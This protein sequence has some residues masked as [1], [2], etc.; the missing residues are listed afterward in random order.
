MLREDAAYA[1]KAARISAL[2]KDVTELMSALGLAPPVRETGLVG[3]LPFGL[4]DAARPG[5]PAASR[6]SC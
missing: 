6:S 5:D 1:A 4:L 2:A 3:R